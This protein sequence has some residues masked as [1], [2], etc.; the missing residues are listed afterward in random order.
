[1]A[2]GAD[3]MSDCPSFLARGNPTQTGL[4]NPQVVRTAEM[5]GVQAIVFVR[6]KY[7]PPET[8]LLAEEKNIPL[9]HLDT[10]CTENLATYA[11]WPGDC[12]VLTSVKTWEEAF[13]RTQLT[14][15]KSWPNVV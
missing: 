1:M 2:C 7:P 6:G 11:S 5:A 9:L 10:P 12:G 8:N 14:K 3:L 15:T 13:A 4:T